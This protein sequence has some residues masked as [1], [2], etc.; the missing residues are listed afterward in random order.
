MASHGAMGRL[1]PPQDVYRDGQR[2]H[3][4]CHHP[5]SLSGKDGGRSVDREQF[6]AQR[7]EQFIAQ[8]LEQLGIL[9]PNPTYFSHP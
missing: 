6:L 1:F 2:F 5:C 9:R 7:E 4:S 8:R 3:H